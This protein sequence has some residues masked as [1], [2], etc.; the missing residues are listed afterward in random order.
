VIRAVVSM[1]SAVASQSVRLGGILGS[2]F[3]ATDHTD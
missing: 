3:F 2:I 1:A